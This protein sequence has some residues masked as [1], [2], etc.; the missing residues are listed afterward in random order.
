MLRA[1]PALPAQRHAS[2]IGP[3]SGA[4]AAYIDPSRA[5]SEL[6]SLALVSYQHIY[7]T[8]DQTLTRYISLEPASLGI[9]D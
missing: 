8:M 9:E 2:P 6:S 5:P 3:S 1:G 4:A 7:H